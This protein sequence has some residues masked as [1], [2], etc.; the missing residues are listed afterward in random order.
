[1]KKI[2]TKITI[3]ILAVALAVLAFVG[4][5]LIVNKTA[6]YYKNFETEVRSVAESEELFKKTTGQDIFSYLTSHKAELCKSAD[7]EY[8]LLCDGNIVES[9]VSGGI[10]K[11]T[12][13]LRRA[14]EG[15]KSEVPSITAKTLDY[16][17]AVTDEFTVYVIDRKAELRADIAELS[18]LFLQAFIIG[19]LLAGIIGFFISKRLTKSLAKLKDSAKRMS[20]GDF[21]RVSITGRDEIASL[22]DVY[23]EMGEQI[24]KD[25]DE[26]ARVERSRREFVANVSHELKT[27][28]TVIKSYSQ[29]LKDN[30]V[31]KPTEKQFLSVIDSEVDRMT[32]IVSRL[33]KVSRLEEQVSAPQKLEL[34]TICKDILDALSIEADKKG[35]TTELVGRGEAVADRD[36]TVSILTNLISNAVCYS[37]DGGLVKVTV[38]DNR[39]SVYDNGIGIPKED[40]PHLFERFYRTDKARGRKTGGTGLGLA[41]ALECAKSMGANITVQSEAAKYTEF[42]LEF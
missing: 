41:I 42:V 7:R 37:K 11:M 31:D 19:I 23:N 12:D 39:V 33:L 5:S 25:F 8:Y 13:N 15:K 30:E 1:M 18:F 16:A 32:D 21:E 4:V 29:T 2:S 27:P 24:K 26:F 6:N 17:V 36:K 9:S 40:I 10:L 20:D 22:A 3:S 34:D 38:G 14:A 35:L 28:L